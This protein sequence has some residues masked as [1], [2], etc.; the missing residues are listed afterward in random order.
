M[1]QR[2]LV[3]FKYVVLAVCM[4]L[5]ASGV[6]SAESVGQLVSRAQH[7]D[8]AAM[9]TLGIRMY[10]GGYVGI[11]TD[12][13]T[14]LQWLNMAAEKNDDVA[15]L[16]LGDIYAKGFHVPQNKRKAEDYYR[17]A[18]SAGNRNADDRLAKLGVKPAS[19]PRTLPQRPVVVAEDNFDAAEASEPR[20]SVARVG[21]VA[22]SVEGSA[23]A[24]WEGEQ[25]EV[26]ES[27]PRLDALSYR[28]AAGSMAAAAKA[29]GV[30]KVA[31]L[32]FMC[33]GLAST[34]IA[35]TV[36]DRLM[37]EMVDQPDLQCFDRGQMKLVATE[38]AVSCPEGAIGNAEAVLTG[39]VF[40][41]PSNRKGYVAYRLV[42]TADSKILAAGF[43]QVKWDDDELDMF[44]G[45]VRS[46][47]SSSFSLIDPA[48]FDDLKRKVTA[49]LS[50]E[51][52][53]M[54]YDGTQR[55]ENT[56]EARMAY[57]QVLA[58]LSQ[59]NIAMYERE[60]FQ[61]L[62][63]ENSLDGQLANGGSGITAVG[64]T[65]LKQS[66]GTANTV[67]V[68]VLGVPGDNLLFTAQVKQAKGSLARVS[69]SGNDGANG[70][71]NR[72]ARLD[73]DE[74]NVKLVYEAEVVIDDGY[75]PNSY[76]VPC[77]V[78]ANTY[79]CDW[80]FGNYRCTSEEV[81]KELKSFFESALRYI[82]RF[83]PGD[84]DMVEKYLTLGAIYGMVARLPEMDNKELLYIGPAS[85][86]FDEIYKN[87]VVVGTRVVDEVP[88]PHEC[89]IK[90][91]KYP[92]LKGTFKKDPYCY[93]YEYRVQWR[94]G[95][96]YKVY[97][98]VDLTPMK[99][100]L[101]KKENN[102]ND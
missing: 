71:Q 102:E 40:C 97:A 18:Q 91:F 20:S 65:K 94:D 73:K 101:L 93:N 64:H 48:Q 32:P 38:A 82:H 43:K 96:P 34:P 87:V 29:A 68:Q 92:L 46:M 61:S 11:P 70:L 81:P 8:V 50:D 51:K 99:D 42:A 79:D 67:V 85:M 26:S 30:S 86:C 76:H 2:I 33:N 89:W 57:A 98:K 75:Q 4:V 77:C 17:R 54:V 56:L 84:P 39:E 36:R 58:A 6:A 80:D 95:L 10:K 24:R 37:E 63:Q 88:S 1:K 19:A 59:T 27:A 62:A 74:R 53:A 83:S 60:F 15:L 45:S 55:A 90:E 16:F 78:R 72:L 25:V 28:G 100:K 7:R 44:S 41:A 12:R 69:K 49:K 47:G 21:N 31:V 35:D 14:G 52:I 3:R 66:K 22:P 23:S 5:A 13:K 9:R